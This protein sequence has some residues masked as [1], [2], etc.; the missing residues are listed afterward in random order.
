MLSSIVNEAELLAALFQNGKEAYAIC[1][2][3]AELGHPQPSTH[4]ATDN[5]TASGIA[6]DNVWL[7]RSKAMDM[8]YYWV[9][10]RVRQ[11]Q[12][13]VSWKKV[14]KHHPASHHTL[15]QPHYLH[16]PPSLPV[17][18]NYFACLASDSATTSTHVSVLCCPLSNVPTHNGNRIVMILYVVHLYSR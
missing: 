1:S 2:I 6:N 9:R 8:H 16:C 10:N 14:T 3:L 17:T 18:P 13:L 5:S 4:I 7:K 15:M 12:F 11:G